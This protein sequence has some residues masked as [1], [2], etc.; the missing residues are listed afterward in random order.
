MKKFPLTAVNH[1]GLCTVRLPLVLRLAGSGWMVGNPEITTHDLF[2]TFLASG[3]S[4][5][6]F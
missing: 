3:N 6:G 5:Q 1:S 4:M 2:R